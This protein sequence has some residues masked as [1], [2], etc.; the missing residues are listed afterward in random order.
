MLP[1]YHQPTCWNR[2]ICQRLLFIPQP[3]K[4]RPSIIHNSSNNKLNRK[5]SHQCCYLHNIHKRSWHVYIQTKVWKRPFTN[6][7][8]SLSQLII[9]WYSQQLSSEILFRL[10]LGLILWHP[11]QISWILSHLLLLSYSG[12][13]SLALPWWGY[14]YFLVRS[15]CLWF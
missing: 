2:T 1:L 6:K 9:D 5:E 12:S 4:G 7:P 14:G 10:P 15:Q 3:Q 11:D 13:I 8:W